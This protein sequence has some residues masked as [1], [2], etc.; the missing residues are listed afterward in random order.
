M[1]RAGFSLKAR[2]TVLVL[3]AVGLVW[4]GTVVQTWRDAR[5]E[6]DALFDAHLAQAASLL[7]AQPVEELEEID[8]EHAPPLHRYAHKVAFQLWEGGKRL[9]L[10]SANAP[11]EP[12]GTSEPGFSDREIGGRRW[13]VFSIWDAEGEMLVHVGELAEVRAELA[14]EMMRAL[15][16]PLVFALPLLGALIWWAVRGGMRPL[17]SIA[18]QVSRRAPDRLEPIEAGRV[19]GELRPLVER[20]NNLFGLVAR[21]LENERRFTADA[22]HELRTPLAAIRA[23]AQ[24][25]F[26]AAEESERHATLQKVIAGC[27]R[28][29]R[30]VEQLLTLAR[31]DAPLTDQ[32]EPVALHALAAEVIAELAPAAVARRADISLEGAPEIPVAGVAGLLRIMLRNLIDNALRYTPEGGS[33]A[34]CV[35]RESG[36]VKLAVSDTGP[37]IPQAERLRVMD[38]FYRIAGSGQEG[39]GLGLSI[40]ARIVQIHGAAI[41]IDTPVSG[42]GSVVTVTFP[43]AG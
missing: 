25:A 12:L 34:V 19:P 6:I 31:L 16:K 15:L 37:G 20:L 8:T 22:A 39:S 9:R 13:R 41:A 32:F 10:H 36:G 43:P 42:T 29:A 35:T 26:G 11:N 1:T 21:S 28:A 7:I 5:A 14:G 4:A 17:D 24:V 3:L 23:Q 18:D 40:V 27:D 38:R 30:L 2:L 33:V